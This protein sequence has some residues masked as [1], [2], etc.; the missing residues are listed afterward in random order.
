MLF[1]YLLTNTPQ[2]FADVR[3]YWS[4]E[5]V[6][7]VTGETLTGKAANGFLHLSNSGA[8]SLDGAGY[9]EINGQPAI[10]PFWDVTQAEADAALQ[11]TCWIPA[12]IGYFRGGGFSS[13]YVS[14]GGANGMPATM[15]RLNLVKGVGPTLQLAEGYIVDLP[16][17]VFSVINQRT[18]PGWPSTIFVPT[19]TGHGAFKSV[20]GVMDNWGANHGAISYGHIGADLIT[21]A[22][23]LRIPV[24]MHNVA[25][26]DIFRP[27]AWSNFGTEEAEGAD[28]RACQN[29]G[30]LYH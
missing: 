30:P 10:K 9:E 29:F 6:K 4:P 21:L 5:A 14:R 2:I 17:K 27:R 7:R 3:T 28:F 25:E 8:Q 15:T 1:N 16:E 24:Y 22:S 23:A 11:N 18:D 19:L 13:N 26:E 12:N 20:Y